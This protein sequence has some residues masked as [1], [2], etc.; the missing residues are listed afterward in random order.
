M[1]T[2][3]HR[4]YHDAVESLRL[5]SEVS[6]ILCIRN[7]CHY[8]GYYTQ[9]VINSWNP[10]TLQWTI[11]PRSFVRWKVFRRLKF[12]RSFQ[13]RVWLQLLLYQIQ[14]W[15]SIG[16]TL[17]STGWRSLKS[18]FDEYNQ[19]LYIIPFLWVRD[20]R[21]LSSPFK[22]HNN[23]FTASK[24]IVVLASSHLSSSI[25]LP[26]LCSLRFQIA[27]SSFLKDVTHTMQE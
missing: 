22:L 14:L 7:E 6:R 12:F 11:R 23:I 2:C 1:G 24:T 21:F 8:C 18:C 13:E 26:A 15:G 3:N 5:D 27:P 16:R 25:F 17:D 10:S 19:H 9:L 20:D 4:S